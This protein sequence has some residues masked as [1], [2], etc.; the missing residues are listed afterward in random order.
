MLGDPA[1]TR[2]RRAC[3]TSRPADFAELKSELPCVHANLNE[4]PIHELL[5][6]AGLASSNGEARRF[7]TGGAVYVNGDQ[8]QPEKMA[9]NDADVIAGH[10]LL[11][12][13]KN[14]LA[15]VEIS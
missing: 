2:S 13:G 7:I 3:A 6:K 8:L 14:T 9:F 11:R 4:T 12:R 5:V 1:V 15:V 10:A